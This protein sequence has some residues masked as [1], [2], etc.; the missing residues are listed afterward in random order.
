MFSCLN[1]VPIAE[2]DISHY[3]NIPNGGTNFITVA[4]HQQEEPIGGFL[5]DQSR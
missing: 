1:R 3:P 5:H 2:T 4:F